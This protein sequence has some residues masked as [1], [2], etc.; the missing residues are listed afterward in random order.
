MQRSLTPPG[1]SPPHHNGIYG[2]A[3]RMFGARRHP[4]V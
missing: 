1:P 2:F 3:F 4:G